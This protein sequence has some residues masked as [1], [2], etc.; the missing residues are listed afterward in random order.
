MRAV[1]VTLLLVVAADVAACVCVPVAPKTAFKNADVVFLGEVI[2]EDEAAFS[3]G[4][5][6]VGI[7]AALSA[8]ARSWS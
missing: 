7:P 5:G 8:A 1:P 3:A 4:W 2:D 6:P